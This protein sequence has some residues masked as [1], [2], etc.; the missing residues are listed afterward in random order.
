MAGN[1]AYLWGAG[2]VA[3]ESFSL[4]YVSMN[5]EKPFVSSSIVARTLIKSNPPGWV[6]IQLMQCGQKQ[7]LALPCMP[8]MTGS[9]CVS[10]NAL[11]GKAALRE[12]ALPVMR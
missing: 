9:P 12:K 8:P 7:C 5:G 4:K 10:T 2:V 1:V 11:D 6:N 3:Q